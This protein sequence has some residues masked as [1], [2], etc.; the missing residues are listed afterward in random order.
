MLQAPWLWWALTG[1]Q[2][3]AREESPWMQGLIHSSVAVVTEKGWWYV[4]STM[5]LL[6]C[7]SLGTHM[8]LPSVGAA[9]M[10]TSSLNHW[11]CC[12]DGSGPRRNGLNWSNL[13]LV[14][15]LVLP[16]F[17]VCLL[18]RHY[19][20]QSY[21]PSGY[22]PYP[23]SSFVS[24]PQLV[25]C[26]GKEAGE[27]IEAIYNCILSHS[28]SITE[29]LWIF[30]I[31]CLVRTKTGDSALLRETQLK[32]IQGQFKLRIFSQLSLMSTAYYI[33]AY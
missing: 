5:E 2:L 12:R 27:S 21:T 20:L 7:I 32:M 9:S 3:V 11:Q 15:G 33:T 17:S 4:G 26:S 1:P 18:S 29:C 23:R 13:F 6:S 31:Y 25:L 16:G 14:W 10:A 24:L 28:L 22:S 8:V 19:N 30:K